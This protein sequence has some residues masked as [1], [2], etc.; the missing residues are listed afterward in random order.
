M[1]REVVAVG[2]V[3]PELAVPITRTLIVAGA[4]ATRDYEDVHHDPQRA[5]ERGTPDTYMSI[6]NTNGLVGRYVT[7]WAGPAARLTKLK[8]RLGVPN[9]PGDTMTLTGE[10][11]AVDGDTVRIAVRGTNSKG[12]HAL[13][14]ITVLL[15]EATP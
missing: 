13:S 3:L 5:V 10:V 12:A 11:V 4:L 8:T 9:F 15:P 6:N 14:E 7:D 2:D 1:N